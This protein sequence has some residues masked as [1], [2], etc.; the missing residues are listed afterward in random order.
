MRCMAVRSVTSGA[1][2]AEGALYGIDLRCW[3]WVPMSPPRVG[4]GEG[5]T[6]RYRTYAPVHADVWAANRRT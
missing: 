1:T 5:L 3:A 2:Y 6:W 4:A